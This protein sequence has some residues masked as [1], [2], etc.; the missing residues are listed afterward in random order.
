[1]LVEDAAPAEERAA[2]AEVL[3]SLAPEPGAV[4]AGAAGAVAAVVLSMLVLL[5][6]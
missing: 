1:M 2:A 6:G 4:L 3:S 5:R